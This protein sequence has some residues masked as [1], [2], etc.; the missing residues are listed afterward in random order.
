MLGFLVS[1]ALTFSVKKF[2]GV[3]PVDENGS[4]YFEAP[5]LRSLFFIALDREDNS[6]KRMQSFSS[7]MPGEFTG[8]IGCHEHRAQTSRTT[9]ASKS[10]AMTRA[11]NALPSC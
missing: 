10:L 9:V 7:V 3:V 8:C 2:L 4:A 5:A 6:V 1:A 11:P